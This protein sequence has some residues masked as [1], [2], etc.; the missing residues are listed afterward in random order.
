[1]PSQV[2]SRNM[3]SKWVVVGASGF[4]G[5][6]VI[7]E[8]G[9]RGDVVITLPAP[10]LVA[11]AWSTV[12]Q[13]VDQIV[14]SEAQIRR[15]AQAI[16]SGDI[17]INAAGLADPSSAA[18]PEL[19]GANAL[20]PRFLA[21][22]ARVAGAKHFVHL[23]SAA[24][25]GLA[26]VLSS[27]PSTYAFSPYSEA[28]SMGESLLLDM[29]PGGTPTT[30]IRATSVQ[31]P[32]RVTTRKLQNLA[33]SRLASVASPG[34]QPTP[35]SSI[36]GLVSFVLQKA[37]VP[38]QASRILLQPWEG[39]TVRSVLELASG[40]KAPVVLPAV[41]CRTV[42]ACGKMGAS[43]FGSRVSSHVR[44]LELMWFGQ[45]QAEGEQDVPAADGPSLN[46]VR[47]LTPPS[48]E[49]EEAGKI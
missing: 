37:A 1:M 19:F 12:D 11:E 48:T 23:S 29:A 6:A 8:L 15:F 20:L 27:S 39:G 21:E 22:A 40:G 34:T 3:A 25:Q 42:I 16:D 36:Y 33:L 35:V 41:L 18:T 5:S 13:L 38:P 30:I 7:D 26:K 46:L 2:E 32:G 49:T 31:G 9:R 17:V 45:R 47:V 4:V 24:V 10:R 14:R 43:I 28:K 44:R